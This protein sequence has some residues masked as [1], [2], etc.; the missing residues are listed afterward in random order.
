MHH[1]T[2]DQAAELRRTLESLEQ[3]LE[4]L[5]DDSEEATR[6]VDLDQP[7]G[8]LSRMDALQNQQMAQANR[9]QH[10]ARLT[11]IRAALTAFANGTYG[12]CCA[13]ATPISLPRLRALPET[14]LCLSCQESLS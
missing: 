10:E 12:I 8:R 1:L 2:P 7:I 9:D 3:E 6:P 11:H 13:C 14:T 5:V 4:T